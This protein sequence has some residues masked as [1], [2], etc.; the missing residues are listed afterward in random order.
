MNINFAIFVILA[1]VAVVLLLEGGFV[2]WN[3]NKSPEVKRI[4]GRLRAISAGT[5]EQSDGQLYKERVLSNTPALHRLLLRLPRVH[6]IDRM[7]IQSGSTLSVWHFIVICGLLALGTLLL[8][9]V[10]RW[11]FLWI[12]VAMALMAVLPVLYQKWKSNQRLSRI[13]AQLP[14]AMDLISRALRAGHSFPSALSMVG[15][16]AQEPIASEFK[17]T[18][19]E[20]SFGISN[21]QALNNLAARV[22][23]ADLR[24]F[25]MAV[26][27]QRETGGNLSELLGKL[28]TLIRERFKLF[29]KIRVLAAEGK[30]SAWIL[31]LLPFGVA[32]VIYIMNPKYMAILFTDPLGVTW[33]IGALILM[34]IGIFSMWRI[35]DIHV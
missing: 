21:D 16:E 32:G 12:V 5:H 2:L 4:E 29:G 35:I 8:G 27:I 26:I 15:N 9:L 25:V 7:L 31:T 24:Y 19:D 14:D 28:S 10:F 17:T 13:E 23:S 22:P 20:I 6:Q 33:V 1:F 30:L 11:P 3:D 34:A 18:F